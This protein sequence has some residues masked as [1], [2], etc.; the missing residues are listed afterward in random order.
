VK[1]AFRNTV[2]IL[3]DPEGWAGRVAKRGRSNRQNRPSVYRLLG[4]RRFDSDEMVRDSTPL[5]QKADRPIQI[6]P[7]ATMT[8]RET[9]G[10][11]KSPLLKWDRSMPTS[12]STTAQVPEG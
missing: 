9:E 6:F 4:S 7:L 5:S 12:T 10:S 11:A 2:H 3:L 1:K 8:S